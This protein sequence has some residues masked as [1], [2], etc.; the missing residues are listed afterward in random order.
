MEGT[1]KNGHA[2]TIYISEDMTSILCSYCYQKMCEAKAGGFEM[3]D[4]VDKQMVEDL[5]GHGD[6]GFL[7]R[8]YCH[9]QL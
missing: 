4:G 6:T 7:E 8:A 5:V 3:S 2:R 1:T 9:P